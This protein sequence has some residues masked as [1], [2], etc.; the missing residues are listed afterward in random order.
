MNIARAK[1]AEH[2]SEEAK[3]EN[4]ILRKEIKKLQSQLANK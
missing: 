3:S 1:E 2:K 4:E